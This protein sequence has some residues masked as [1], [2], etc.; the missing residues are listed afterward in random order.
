MPSDLP[1]LGWRIESKGNTRIREIKGRPFAGLFLFIDNPLMS[2]R[3][4]GACT[5][6]CEG[7]MS[8]KVI[9][10]SP[11]NPCKHCTAAGCGIYATRP[12]DP[13]RTFKC[14]W[15][16]DGSPMPDHLRP[17]KSLAIVQLNRKWK[18]R[19]IISA[20][21]VGATIP[22]E[23]LDWL[24]AYAREQNRPLL[25]LENLF[26]DGK[27][28]GYKQT[29]YGPPDFVQAVKNSIGLGDVRLI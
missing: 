25:F 19:D 10:F 15:L 23:T 20:T 6:C 21:P 28:I 4:C 11:G 27:F 9:D 5:V 2:S 22:Q 7:W 3:E 29:G 1:T 24:M 17:D 16:Q 18:G 8:S 12:V 26:E 13:C 14:A